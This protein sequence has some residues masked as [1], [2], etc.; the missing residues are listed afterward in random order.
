MSR[1]PT[2]LAVTALAALSLMLML[3]LVATGGAAQ[4][5]ASPPAVPRSIDGPTAIVPEDPYCFAWDLSNYTGVDVDGLTLRLQG[6]HA[7]SA[8]YTDTLNPFF[9]LDTGYEGGTDSYRL[10]FTDGLAYD[11][12]LVHVG[13]CT[14][15]P[16]AR[17]SAAPNALD[18]TQGISTVQPAPLIVGVELS[19]LSTDQLAVNLI[20]EQTLTV[21]L[22][23]FVLL[24]AEVAL[25]LD[26]LIGDIAATLPLAGEGITEPITLAPN[27]AY[28]V[29]FTDL[30]RG[31]GY[32]IEAQLSA[33]DDAFNN[34]RVFA[35][36]GLPPYRTYLPLI[37]R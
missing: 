21:T 22:D 34:V 25:S 37:R 3:G 28:S 12:D 23:N 14:D 7:V 24:D 16:Y 31:H 5:G 4:A 11:S 1:T 27:A 29:T 18:W 20:N 13:L 8:V 6:N 9:G 17:L 19:W 10:V 36:T 15:L 33:E 2:V 35:Q 26:D 32:A 30:L